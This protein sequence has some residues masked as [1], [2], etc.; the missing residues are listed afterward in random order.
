MV[1]VLEKVKTKHAWTGSDQPRVEVKIPSNCLD[2]L[3]SF[4]SQVHCPLPRGIRFGV[5]RLKPHYVASAIETSTH[6]PPH[7][8]S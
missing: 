4:I 6:L 1:S 5:T 2:Q 3:G 8:L 7:R